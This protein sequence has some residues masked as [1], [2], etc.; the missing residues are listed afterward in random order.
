MEI[1]ETLKKDTG[2]STD[3]IFKREQIGNLEIYLV[4]SETLASGDYINEYI[5]ESLVEAR[6]VTSQSLENILPDSNT[7]IPK[8]YQEMLEF[9]YKGFCLVITKGK[10]I[11]IEAKKDIDRSVATAENEVSLV[12]PK[13]SFTE[14]FNMN[15][16]LIRKRIRTNKLRVDEKFIGQLSNTKV[17]IC[18]MENIASKKLIQN[19]KRRLAEI[20]IDGIID[21]SYLK[22]NLIDKKTIFPVIN[23]TERPDLA[24][25]S[26]LEGK[27]II[28]ADNSPYAIIIPTFFLD[29][30]HAPDDYYQK[31]INI[32]FIRLIRLLA[33]AIAIFIPGLYIAYTTHNSSSLPINLLIN[34]I[35]QRSSVPFPS[36]I[37]CI[38]MILCFEILRETDLRIPSKTS[39]AISILGGLILG[40]AAVSAGIISPI[41]IIIVAIS[42]IS[43]L[44]FSNL[45]MIYLI[46]YLRIINI[47]LCSIFGIFGCVITFLFIMIEL[48]G[49]ENFN[50]SYI[51][52]FAPINREIDDS[53][54]KID[55]KVKRRNP[56]L[57]KKNNI[58]GR[59]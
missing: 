53:L 19:V 25:Q 45:A 38:T 37:E 11:A 26:L 39:S 59:S 27:I 46:R 40:E 43:G 58:R 12:G 44:I 50:L 5:L 47:F 30:F 54:I 41:M 24:S 22:N 31:N 17:G 21:S 55:N 48:S 34:L 28:I 13:D 8:N 20:D 42:S 9:I 51:A 56:L 29:Y 33:F 6:E 23:Q 15:I 57:S 32:S 7:S 14:N 52:P 1:I 3:I 36:F 2:E 18:Y 49:I 10:V 16:G 35:V 4:F